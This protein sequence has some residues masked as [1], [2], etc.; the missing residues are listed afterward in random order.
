LHPL[1]FQ[2]IDLGNSDSLQSLGHIL[3][4][5]VKDNIVRLPENTGK[6]T[7][8]MVQV[9]KGLQITA[10]NILLHDR[11]ELVKIAP[12]PG[13]NKV[14][15]LTYTF[16]P[17]HFLF[18][19][20]KAQSEIKLNG[21]AHLLFDPGN[22]DVKFTILPG[23]ETR[24]L[25]ISMETKWLEEEFDNYLSI[26][27]QPMEDFINGDKPVLCYHPV[28]PPEYKNAL[29]LFHQFVTEPLDIFQI[30]GNTLLL[31]S[32]FFKNFFSKT[33]GEAEESNVLHY[34]KMK[35]VE[36]ILTSHVDK[37]LPSLNALAQQV[38]LSESTLKRYF[39]LTF[40]TSIYDYYLQRKMEYAKTLLMEQ[41]LPVKEVAYMLGY[42]KSSSFIRIFK[43]NYKQPPGFLRKST[44]IV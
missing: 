7:I 34:E 43:K 15:N 19:S 40:G 1:S 39:K 14:L 11:L 30:K 27:R 6:G 25:A 28:L 9:S 22:Q 20:A 35:A 18:Q 12:L 41:R 17:G 4:A 38:A 32:H 8:Q 33:L 3:G 23:V 13:A 31:L 24:A 26:F 44:P 21:A 16:T 29:E 36:T 2:F 5:Q 10:W 37:N 42:E